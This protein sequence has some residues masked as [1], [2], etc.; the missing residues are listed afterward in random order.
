MARTASW[1]QKEFMLYENSVF[2]SKLNMVPEFLTRIF[3]DLFCNSDA[4]SI[5]EKI[6][7]ITELW[8]IRVQ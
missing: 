5:F 1:I 2:S 8:Q 6:L 4:P 7:F 3:F